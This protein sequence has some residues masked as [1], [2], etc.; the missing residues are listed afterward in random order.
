MKPITVPI[1]DVID[2][3]TFSPKEVPDLLEEYLNACLE[4]DIRSVRIIHGKGRGFLRN[5]VERVLRSLP[6]VAGFSQAPPSAGGWGATIVEL[7][8][9]P[10]FESPEWA[11]YLD[12][13]ARTMGL[14]L[15]EQQIAAFAVH[16]R[17]LM[18]WNRFA[19]LTAIRDPLEIAVKQFLDT[20]PLCP[21]LPDRS[22]VLDLGSGGGFPGIPLK[23]LRPDLNLTLIDASRKKVSFLRHVIRTLHLNCIGARQI[24]AEGLAGEI[25]RRAGAQAKGGGPAEAPLETD[26][27]VRGLD[28]GCA[29]GGTDGALA[30]PADEALRYDVVV[31]KAAFKLEMLFD[32]AVPLLRR[33]SLLVAMKGK[34]VETELDPLR[35]KTGKDGFHIAVETYRL[36]H[37]DIKR[38]LV[39]LTR[40]A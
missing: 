6:V 36:P 38:S 19:S 12:R 14:P 39:L 16:A 40:S 23:I 27:V 10:D 11:E 5:Q 17:E 13:G 15:K 7:K 4:A 26:E 8:K 28:L 33:S 1:E 37:I 2:L 35:T 3:H 32:L 34:T 31:S 9:G 18:S 30:G 29:V 20:I 25:G 22:R 24:R 21:L